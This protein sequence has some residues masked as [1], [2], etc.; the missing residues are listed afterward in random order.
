[1]AMPGHGTG[2]SVERE[3]LASNTYFTAMVLA[4]YDNILG[5]TMLKVWGGKP[6]DCQDEAAP[7]TG[8]YNYDIYSKDSN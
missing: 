5:P 8:N 7:P 1:M 3:R 6:T 2:Q 4:V